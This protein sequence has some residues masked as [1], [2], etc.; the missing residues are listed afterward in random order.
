MALCQQLTGEEPLAYLDSFFNKNPVPNISNVPMPWA[1][2][3]VLLVAVGRQAFQSWGKGDDEEAAATHK[4]GLTALAESR[5]RGQDGLGFRVVREYQKMDI[6]DKRGWSF[7]QVVAVLFWVPP[8]LDAAH[9]LVKSS[10][11]MDGRSAIDGEGEREKPGRHPDQRGE[12]A[13]NRR[14][15]PSASFH[16]NDTESW[17][18]GENLLTSAGRVRRQVADASVLCAITR[19][20][21][22]QRVGDPGQNEQ[23]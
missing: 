19:R 3:S 13:A 14:G 12:E 22:Y 1:F 2:A 7:G 21:A 16:P 18:D 20:P 23:V 5:R 10:R 17:S 4:P 15:E 6:I 11:R 8:V 9:A